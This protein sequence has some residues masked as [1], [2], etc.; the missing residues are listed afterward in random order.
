MTI[1]DRRVALPAMLALVAIAG[2]GGGSDSA[3]APVESGSSR[4]A[5][6]LAVP[7]I[8]A[9]PSDPS[10]AEPS[11]GILIWDVPQG[12]V[13]EAPGSSM[14]FAQYRVPGPAGHGECAVFY[15]GPGQGGDAAANAVR[16]AR[17]FE[18]PGGGSAVDAMEMHDLDGAAVPVLLVSVTGTY[19]GGMTMTDAPAEKLP[20]AMLLGGIAQ[21]PDAPWFFKFTGPEAT[22]RA[23]HDAFVDMMKSIRVGKR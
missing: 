8:A 9:P 19:D 11:A 22:V 2:C 5:R 16:W 17:Q 12:W 6:T 3:P 4:A 21:G 1:E 7:G 20:G 14:R 15:F 18:Q 10:A 13:G 23:Q